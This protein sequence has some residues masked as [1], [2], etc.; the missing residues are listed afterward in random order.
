MRRGGYGVVYNNEKEKQRYKLN[1]IRDLREA[2]LELLGRYIDDIERLFDKFEEY[3]A[4]EKEVETQQNAITE[5]LTPSIWRESS[6]SDDCEIAPAELCPNLVNLI[7]A[8]G[9]RL[10][11]QDY[12]LYLSKS[13]KWI[14][15]FR[16]G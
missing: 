7:K 15:R 6:F 10:T 4:V 9:G 2:I 1:N 13:G 16:R 11:L 5:L 12:K 8:N 3:N 14:K